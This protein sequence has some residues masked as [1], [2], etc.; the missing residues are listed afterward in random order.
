MGAAVP[1]KASE[2]ILYFVS[3]HLFLLRKS[4]IYCNYLV[5]SMYNRFLCT[6]AT[7]EGKKVKPTVIPSKSHSIAIFIMILVLDSLMVI[8]PTKPYPGFRYTLPVPTVRWVHFWF[9]LFV[10]AFLAATSHFCTYHHFF[11]SLCPTILGF[12]FLALHEKASFA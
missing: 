3:G 2:T 6:R 12:S 11:V 10:K 1:G 4:V 9:L 8:F 5:H 7:K